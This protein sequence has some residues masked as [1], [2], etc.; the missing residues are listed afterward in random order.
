LTRKYPTTSTTAKTKT[1]TTTTT[2]TTAG[3]NKMKFAVKQS[4][5]FYTKETY[6]FPQNQVFFEQAKKGRSEGE[7]L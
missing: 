1:V 6:F 3:P 7:S 4:C 2:V 5:P